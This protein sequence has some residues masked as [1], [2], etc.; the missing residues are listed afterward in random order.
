MGLNTHVVNERGNVGTRVQ[1]GGFTAS[2]AQG[3]AAGLRWRAGGSRG[4]QGGSCLPCQ[5]SGLG[6]GGTQKSFL[7]PGIGAYSEM[8]PWR[9]HGKNGEPHK[10]T[11]QKAGTESAMELETDST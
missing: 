10:E 6:S 7:K 2:A 11:N 1:W 9:V 4:H 8:H 3:R 5:S